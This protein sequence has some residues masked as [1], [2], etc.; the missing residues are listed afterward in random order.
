MMAARNTGD[1]LR[2][3][4]QADLAHEGRIGHCESGSAKR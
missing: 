1:G 2:G 3:G 4:G